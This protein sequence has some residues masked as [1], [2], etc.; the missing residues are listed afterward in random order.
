MEVAPKF[1]ESCMQSQ[2]L[3]NDEGSNPRA[4]NFEHRSRI[5]ALPFWTIVSKQNGGL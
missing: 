3:M 2:P 5:S 4:E 1:V